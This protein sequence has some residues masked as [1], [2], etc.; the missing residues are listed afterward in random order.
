MGEDNVEE[1]V[2]IKK[3]K[4]NDIQLGNIMLLGPIRY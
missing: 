2:K 4:R 1:E 3:K